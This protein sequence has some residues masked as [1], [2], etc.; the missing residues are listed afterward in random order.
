MGF[1]ASVSLIPLLALF[2]F[3]VFMKFYPIGAE[4]AERITREKLKLHAVKA[5]K[6]KSK[7]E[8]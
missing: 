8:F 3:L 5:E 2:A 4:E 6:I 7:D 1:R